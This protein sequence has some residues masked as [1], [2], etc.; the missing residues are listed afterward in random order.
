MNR[1]IDQRISQAVVEV[2][3]VAADGD[4]AFEAATLCLPL[5]LW[6]A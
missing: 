4:A 1:S 3:A 6:G 5:I 2:A